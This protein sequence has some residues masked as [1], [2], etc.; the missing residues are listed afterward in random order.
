MLIQAP[1]ATRSGYGNH[2]RD[3]IESLIDMDKFD[4]KIMS[5]RWGDCSMN[6]LDENNPVH[7]EIL[8]RIISPQNPLNTQPDINVEI[9]VLTTINLHCF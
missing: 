9:R 1:V 3:L 4:I 7:Q 6:A 8:K 5:L 2:S